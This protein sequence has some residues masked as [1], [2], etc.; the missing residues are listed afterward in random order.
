M[1]KSDEVVELATEGV[2]ALVSLATLGLV[3]L[4]PPKP[5]DLEV[6]VEDKDGNR[7]TG[8]LTKRS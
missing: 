1:A 7:Y 6:E 3:D 2:A 5:K 8:K 4:D